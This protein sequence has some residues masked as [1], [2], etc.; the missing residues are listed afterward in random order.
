MDLYAK[1]IFALDTENAFKIGPLITALETQGHTI[2]KLNLG[3]PDFN[4]PEFIKEEVKKQLDENNT[5]YCDPKG[6]YSLREAISHQ[7]YQTHGLAVSP[8]QVVVFPGAKPSIGFSQQVYCDP[9]DEIIYPS[10]GFPIYESF[11]HYVG[12]VPVPLHLSEE[13]GF[14]FTAE[15]LME[16]LSP[17][18]KMIFLNFPSNPTGG[19][20]TQ[21]QLE[22]IASVI[23][24]KCDPNIRIYSDEIYEHIIYENQAHCSI[25]SIPDMA[26]RTIISSGFSKSYAWT[27][28]RIGYAIFPSETE[29]D[30]FKNLNI[31]YFSCVS[32]YNQEGAKIALTH[33]QAQQHIAKMVNIFEERRNYVIQTLNEIPGIHCQKP[34]GTFYAFPNIKELCENLNID[35]FYQNLPLEAQKQTSPSTLFQMFA[36]YYHNVAILDRKSFGKIGSQGKH[37]IRISYASDITILK[38]GMARLRNASQDSQGFKKFTQTTLV[39]KK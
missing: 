2:V 4:V 20:A 15:Q 1:R 37:Y 27:G 24:K 12:A 35:Q 17:K 9:G 32:P 38:E 7:I 26:K 39:H 29:A 30:L 3:E 25:A 18:T 23:L 19:I 10:P 28:G 6:L 34:K 11:I 16:H 8:E 22:D 13:N 33:P 14:T 21:K 36:L 5:H 31:N